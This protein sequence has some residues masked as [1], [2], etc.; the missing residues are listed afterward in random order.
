MGRWPWT[1]TQASK[2]Q[3]LDF[4][5]TQWTQLLCH[6]LTHQQQH[7]RM[8]QRMEGIQRIQRPQ[9]IQTTTVLE[10]TLRLAYLSALRRMLTST[11]RVSMTAWRAVK[12]NNLL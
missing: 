12:W 9:G 10:E 2:W 4:S 6:Q 8:E 3:W 5:T 1:T 7:Q 11:R